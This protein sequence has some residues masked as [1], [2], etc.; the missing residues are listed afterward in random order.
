MKKLTLFLFILIL[1]FSAFSFAEKTDLKPQAVCPV[2]GGQ[3]DKNVFMEYQGQR[4]YFCWPGCKEIF[5]KDAE[6]YMRELADKKVILE[7]LQQVCPVMVGHGTPCIINKN[8]HTDYKGR[9]VYFCSE[10][11]KEDFL[12]DPEKYLKNLAVESPDK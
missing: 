12:K 9:R 1:S 4:I 5:S 8:I 11:C 6:K 2:M 10:I 7:S 3:I